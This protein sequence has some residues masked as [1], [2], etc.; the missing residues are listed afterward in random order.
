MFFVFSSRRRHTRCALVTGVQT[1]ALPISA[2]Y[3]DATTRNRFF[4]QARSDRKPI[5]FPK[6]SHSRD[7][8]P[9]LFGEG[10][11]RWRSAR[12]VIEWDKPGK[13]L[14]GR[15]KGLASKTLDRTLA[16]ARKFNWPTA[17]EIGRAH[18]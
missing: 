11:M 1:C 5:R 13:S 16:G 10:D 18:V 4:R 2:D 14:W 7:G 15:R 6:P 9:D 8:K 17:Y 12:E 3:G